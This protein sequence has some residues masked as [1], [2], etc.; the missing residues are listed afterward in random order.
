MRTSRPTARPMPSMKPIGSV[1]DPMVIPGQLAF[2]P[3]VLPVGNTDA[4]GVV[5]SRQYELLS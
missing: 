2:A 3:S 5:R 4:P 1:N